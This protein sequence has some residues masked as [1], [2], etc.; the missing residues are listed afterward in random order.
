MAAPDVDQVLDNVYQLVSTQLKDFLNGTPQINPSNVD[1]IIKVVMECI[2]VFSSGQVAALSSTR[3]AELGKQLLK[4]I[5]A[6]L[7]KSG[8]ISQES[9]QF[10]NTIVD[11]VGP[12][13]FKLIVM[14]DK[15]YIHINEQIQEAVKDGCGC[16]GAKPAPAP[17]KSGKGKTRK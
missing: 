3:K 15:G 2:D 9:L 4:K 8:K 14:A 13:I 10:W 12:A 6:D 11:H 7:V 16:F 17:A 1:E 5:F